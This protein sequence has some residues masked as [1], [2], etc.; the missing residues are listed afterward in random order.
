MALVPVG[1]FDV[2]INV[3][4]TQ[5][6]SETIQE[7]KTGANAYN[8]SE[9][10]DFDA[11]FSGDVSSSVD[12]GGDDNYYDSKSETLSDSQTV[13]GATS[14]TSINLSDNGSIDFNLTANA[15]V[16][17]SL[18]LV[19]S[20]EI[21]GNDVTGKTKNISENDTAVQMMT[22]C[23]KL[24]IELIKERDS[25]DFDDQF[26]L[27]PAGSVGYIIINNATLGTQKTYEPYAA[28]QMDFSLEWGSMTGAWEIREYNYDYSGSV[29]IY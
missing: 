8:I 5:R 21:V 18:N 3:N 20:F 15:S 25:N 24:E 6:V 13:T 2:E 23:D 10:F 1:K 12:I 11:S 19:N 27:N 22:S 17:S 26:E 9:A 16:S 4:G 14:N 7:D 28:G 29:S